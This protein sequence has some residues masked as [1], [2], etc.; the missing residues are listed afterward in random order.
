MDRRFASL[1]GAGRASI[2]S[3][4][5]N[6]V[7]MIKIKYKQKKDQSIFITHKLEKTEHINAVELD[8]LY[9][10]EIPTLCSPQDTLQVSESRL[11]YCLRGY[12]DLVQHLAGGVGFNEF[13]SIVMSIVKTIQACNAYGIPSG[14][15]ELRPEYVFVDN[16]TGQLCLLYWPLVTLDTNDDLRSAFLTFS[17]CY[18][19]LEQDEGCKFMYQSLFETRSRFNV[20]QFEKSL[21]AVQ[22]QYLSRSGIREHS[23]FFRFILLEKATSRRID[24]SRFPFTVGRSDPQCNYLCQNDG[25]MSRIH[26]QLYKKGDS[27]YCSDQNSSNGTIINGK[28]RLTNKTWNDFGDLQ[29]RRG[30]VKLRHGDTITAGETT[31]ICLLE[32]AANTRS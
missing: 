27:V 7:P 11:R 20:I 29:T 10:N 1:P 16:L 6:G 23:S 2:P 13:C 15:L 28:Y 26:F 8:I 31:F 5:D 3:V 32:Y 25:S 30:D 21:A 17:D 12:H 4:S 9:K 19:P 18:V 24:V 14:N 22:S